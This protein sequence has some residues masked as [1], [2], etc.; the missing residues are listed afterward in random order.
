MDEKPVTC[1]IIHDN[2]ENSRAY[3]IRRAQLI[4]ADLPYNLGSK[5]YGMK[6]AT[7]RREKASWRTKRL[8]TQTTAST[9][10]IS[11]PLPHGF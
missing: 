8:S 7:V 2:F 4:L 3:N 5:M 9:F 10:R 11:S 1:E 6:T